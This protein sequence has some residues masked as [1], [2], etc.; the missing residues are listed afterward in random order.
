MPHIVADD[1]SGRTDSCFWTSSAVPAP[2]ES[3]LGDSASIFILAFSADNGWSRVFIIEFGA[4]NASLLFLRAR[5]LSLL[6]KKVEKAIVIAGTYQNTIIAMM[7]IPPAMPP[8]ADPR[9]KPVTPLPPLPSLLGVFGGG[10]LTP[11]DAA[12]LGNVVVDT[13]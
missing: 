5:H 7:I 1:F 2:D 13:L 8:N 11:D 10:T 3:E 4:L 6:E 9:V 12:G